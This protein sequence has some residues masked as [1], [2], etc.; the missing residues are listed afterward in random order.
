MTWAVKQVPAPGGVQI[1]ENTRDNNDFLLETRIEEVESI[2]DALG[3]AREIKPQVERR[4]GHVRELKADF[5]ETS[6][7]E[8]ALGAEVHLQRAHLVADLG[9]GEHL[10][11]GFLERHV[12]AAVDVG[13][14]GSDGFDEFLGAEDPCYAPSGEAESLRETIENEYVVLVDVFDVVGRGDDSAVAVGCVVVSAVEFIHDERRAVAADVLNLSELNFKSVMCFT[15]WN[16]GSLDLRVR[17]ELS[18]WIPWVRCQ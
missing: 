2:V 15:S 10:H 9:W 7:D 8:I 13:T 4:V 11:G 1:E 12:A 16:S 6:N 3:Q 18:S 5:L 17:N 14:A